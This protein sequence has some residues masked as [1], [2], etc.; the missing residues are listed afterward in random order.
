[1]KKYLAL[2]I[3]PLLLLGATYKSREVNQN[4]MFDGDKSLDLLE[5]ISGKWV[6]QPHPQLNQPTLSQTI[7]YADFPKALIKDHEFYDFE[8]TTRLYISSANEDT[9]SGGMILRY[10]NLYSFYMLFLNAKE[11]RVTLT[12]ASLAGLKVVKRENRSFEPNKWYELKANCYLDTI[13]VFVDGEPI[14]EAEDDTSTGGKIGLVTAGTSEV[15]FD[16]LRVR[17][18]QIEVVR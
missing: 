7:K 11:K 3:L 15:Y 14:F 6:V 1:M 12:K 2:L 5:P 13:K 17:T 8:A 9:Q 4:W 18:E 16:G 10:R